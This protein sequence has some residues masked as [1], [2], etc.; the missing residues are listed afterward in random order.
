MAAAIPRR[1]SPLREV[2]PE[3]AHCSTERRF[4][5]LGEAPFFD[6]L[7]EA[8]LQAVN[9][10]FREVHYDAAEWIWH[11]GDP[12]SE[13]FVVAAGQVKLLQHGAGGK[14]VLFSYAG[15]GDLIGGLAAVGNTH[16]PDGAQAHTACCLLRIRREDFQQLLEAEPTIALKVLN[17]AG[18]QLEQARESIRG[19]SSETAEQRIARTLLSLLERH[20]EEHEQGRLIQLPLPQQ[21]LAAMT[22]TTIETVSRVLSEFRRQGL[23][24]TGRRWVAVSDEAGLARLTEA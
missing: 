14:D 5:L 24:T 1:T 19:L 9:E 17:F 22:G 16:H 7:D 15:T 13:M 23:I 10:R 2:S 8:A 3:L 18:S 4:E 21:D 11:P 12:A 6:H 20:G